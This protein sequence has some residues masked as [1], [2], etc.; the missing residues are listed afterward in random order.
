MAPKQEPQTA[1]TLISF[2]DPA[3]FMLNCYVI[4]SMKE[5]TQRAKFHRYFNRCCAQCISGYIRNSFS[6]IWGGTG[7]QETWSLP[8]RDASALILTYFSRNIPISALEEVNVWYELP[9]IAAPR[10][11]VKHRPNC[12]LNSYW[13]FQLISSFTKDVEAPTK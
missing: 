6:L 5:E 10:N 12:L 11:I 2:Q 4:S 1:P 3:S 8:C 9:S 13:L 7:I